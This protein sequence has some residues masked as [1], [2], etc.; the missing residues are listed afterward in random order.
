MKK[1]LTI[2]IAISLFSCNTKKNV[3]ADYDLNKNEE[4]QISLKANHTTGFSWKWIK[5]ESS[6]LVDTVSVNYIP[7]KVNGEIVGSGGNEIWKFKANVIG[8]DTL[9]FEYQ[10]PWQPNSTVETKKIII[11]IN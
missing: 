6:Q 2:I 4:F 3:K 1:V 10:Q 9:K 11:K 7:K 8:I 5:S